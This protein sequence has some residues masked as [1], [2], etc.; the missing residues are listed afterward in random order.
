MSSTKTGF[1]CKSRK[2]GT[3]NKIVHV[4]VLGAGN[5]SRQCHLPTLE[6]L[7]KEQSIEIAGIWD[8]SADNAR[9][10]SATFG[11]NRVYPSIDD[12]I[13][14]EHIDCFAVIV[15]S[16]LLRQV[17]NRLILRD[18]PI[19]MEKPPGKNYEE[20]C[21]LANSVTMPNVVAF[22]RRYIPIN[23]HFKSLVDQLEEPSLATSHFYRNQRQ[24][25]R[26]ITETGIHAIN[27]MEYLF[28]PVADVHTIKPPSKNSQSESIAI[29]TFTSGMNGVFNFLPNSGSNFER[30]EVHSAEKSLYLFCPHFYTSDHPGKIEIYSQGRLYS[31][32]ACGECSSSGSSGVIHAYRD[33]LQAIHEG[34]ETVSN[35]IN[36]RNSMRIAETIQ[37][38]NNLSV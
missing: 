3:S 5:W 10:A 14:D 11:I 19:L 15:S 33:F 20:A 1:P 21:W 29:A 2:Y 34:K 16:N 31:T 32:I 35:L 13:E 7:K 38:G 26:F 37:T 22:D 12:L 24:T 6:L 18:L 8:R 27:Y 17:I 28:G 4:A 36:A 23:Q 30:Y 9:S 25:E